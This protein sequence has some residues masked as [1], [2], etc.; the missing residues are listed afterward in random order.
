MRFLSSSPKLLAAVAAT[1]ALGALWLAASN[2]GAGHRDADA[3]ERVGASQRHGVGDDSVWAR[4]NLVPE[5]GIKGN[6]QRGP[7]VAQERSQP[8]STGPSWAWGIDVGNGRALYRSWKAYAKTQGGGNAAP[9][10]FIQYL[11]GRKSASPGIVGDAL[12][13]AAAQ[14][15]EVLLVRFLTA[16]ETPW[17]EPTC[18]AFMT[19]VPACHEN[20]CALMSALGAILSSS[21]KSD[22][23]LVAMANS[24]KWHYSECPAESVDMDMLRNAATVWHRVSSE[25]GYTAHAVAGCAPRA[26][27]S[28][29]TARLDMVEQEP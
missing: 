5:P 14:E 13:E 6:F 10:E 20:A 18:Q 24:I 29:V 23:V 7:L 12:K 4:Q 22:T 3:G 11:Q 2:V 15:D 26:A 8:A 1:V 16:R 27:L 19:A 17:D 25:P 9:D 28:A 21:C